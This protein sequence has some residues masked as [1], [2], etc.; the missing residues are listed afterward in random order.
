MTRQAIVNRAMALASR[1]GLDG[2]SIGGLAADLGLSKS[3]LFAHFRSK[4]ALQLQV[5]EEAAARLAELVVEPAL[6][7]PR[8]EP[9]IHKI[10]ELW[11]AWPERGEL[12]G[13][14]VFVAAAV[15]LDDQPGPVRNRLVQQQRDWVDTLSNLARTAVAEGHFRPDVDAEQVAFDLCGIMLAYHQ[16][17]RLLHDPAA[18]RRAQAAFDALLARCRAWH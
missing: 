11:Q 16:W 13:G 14:C 7:A 12:T 15:E 17:S 2:L 3:G 18:E 4:Q 1:V 6:R 10:F 8:G 9:R 5:L